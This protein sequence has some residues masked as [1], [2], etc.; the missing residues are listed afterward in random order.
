MV[1]DFRLECVRN[2]IS[3]IPIAWSDS[4]QPRKGFIKHR[5]R[6]CH[7]AVTWPSSVVTWAAARRRSLIV[8]ASNN[9]DPRVMND[10]CIPWIAHIIAHSSLKNITLKWRWTFNRHHIESRTIH[11]TFGQ[12]FVDNISKSIFLNKTFLFWFRFHN[13]FFFPRFQFHYNDVIMGKMASQIT[14]LVIVY[15]TVYLSANLR[16]HQSSAPLAFVRGNHWGPVNSPHK[17][18]V[19]RKM[20]SFD[21]VIM[22]QQ[23]SIS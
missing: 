3:Y 5:K 7:M 8:F 2:L 10:A 18:P 12:H 13:S 17:G 20:L 16:K 14:S 19:T 1:S 15:S 11:S 4:L 21:D 9:R 23:V 22:S 6:G